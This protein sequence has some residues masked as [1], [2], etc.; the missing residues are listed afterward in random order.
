M[1]R[2]MILIMLALLLVFS[3]ILMAE[4]NQESGKPGMKRTFKLPG[5]GP[6][7]DLLRML[8]DDFGKYAGTCEDS[9][10][11]FMEVSDTWIAM[12]GKAKANGDIDEI[13]FQRYKRLAIVCKL[14]VIP[15]KQ[16]ILNDLIVS[17]INKFQGEPL[18][19]DFQFQGIG[20]VAGKMA[21][22]LINLQKYLDEKK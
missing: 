19:K 21:Q 3:S 2:K 17:E 14:V 12:A 9:L 20:S 8:A 1:T 11:T 13:F 10:K 6:G 7:Y 16:R 4:V 18:G 5:E 22:E 15:D